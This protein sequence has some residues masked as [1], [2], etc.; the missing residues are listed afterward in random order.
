MG[1]SCSSCTALVFC[2]YA[3]MP[4]H[5]NHSY[6]R[7]VCALP[8]LTPFSASLLR[9]TY[10]TVDFH[11]AAARIKRIIN[12]CSRDP[13]VPSFPVRRC[14]RLFCRGFAS[15]HSGRRAAL[16]NL[17]RTRFCHALRRRSRTCRFCVRMLRGCPRTVH[18]IAFLHF[19]NRYCFPQ[20]PTAFLR[21]QTFFLL[22]YV[23]CCAF[24]HLTIFAPSSHRF[25]RFLC[26]FALLHFASL[27][28][29]GSPTHAAF[30]ALLR[31]AFSIAYNSR[32]V[33]CTFT[34]LVTT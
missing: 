4:Y 26:A 14:V 2:R 28:L 21:H 31:C 25:L 10:T 7:L 33:T 16:Q 18:F 24:V 8:F 17:P 19:D 12:C 11:V 20:V 23:V 30:R 9:L 3:R 6:S 34:V 15:G 22:V 32:G 1:R 29:V 27:R 5:Q 13:L